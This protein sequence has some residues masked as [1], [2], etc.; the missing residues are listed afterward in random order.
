MM[1]PTVG[2]AAGAVTIAGL[3][4]ARAAERP[5]Q[6]AFTFLADGEAEGGGLTYGELDRRAAGVAGGLGGGGRFWGRRCRGGGGRCSSPRRAWISSW[7][8]SAA[9]TR[10]WW[11]CP[12]IPRVR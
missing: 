6:V 1:E 9:S 12:P 8:S 3:L 5:G 7:P 10:G 11:P 2:S 4:R